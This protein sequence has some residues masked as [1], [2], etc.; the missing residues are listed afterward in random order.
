[1]IVGAIL[2][3]LAGIVNSIGDLL[4]VGSDLIAY[5]GSIGALAGEHAGPFDAML[6]V[7]PLVQ[8]IAT[9]LGVLYPTVMAYQIV[10]WTFRH[11][12]VV[13]NG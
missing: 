4:P 12:P 13:G 6:P 8:I 11:L 1:M 7:G 10:E 3:L 5:T 2:R 9:A